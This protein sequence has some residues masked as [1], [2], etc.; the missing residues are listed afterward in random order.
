MGPIY[1]TIT[2]GSTIMPTEMKNTPPKRSFTGFTTF[3]MCSA[4]QVPARMEPITKEPRASEKPEDTENTA[5]RK[6]SPM[7]VMSS[8]SLLIYLR[9]NL[10]NDGNR[11]TPIVNQMMRKNT[12]LSTL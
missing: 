7:A 5:M 8:S 6:Q 11:Y 3:S 10:K 2:V 1:S 12:S 9:K 4:S